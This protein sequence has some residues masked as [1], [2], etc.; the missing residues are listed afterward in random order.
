MQLFV[1]VVQVYSL[2]APYTHIYVYMYIHAHSCK[3]KVL[4]LNTAGF[5]GQHNRN[6]QA[7]VLKKICQHVHRCVRYYGL[8]P[9]TRNYLTVLPCCKDVTRIKNNIRANSLVTLLRWRS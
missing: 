1:H 9:I 2:Y 3:K 8:L 4:T 7:S 5:I 6:R